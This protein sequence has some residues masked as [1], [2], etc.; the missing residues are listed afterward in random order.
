MDGVWRPHSSLAS[1]P[2]T[3]RHGTR[4][5]DDRAARAADDRH[6]HRRHQG[7]RRRRR[8]LRHGAERPSA[9]R[10]PGRSVREVEDTIVELV[11]GLRAAVRRRGGRDRGRRLRRRR[12]AP[13]VLF[14]PHLAWRDEP[15]RAA[16]MQRIAVPVVV[17][18]DANTA[19]LAE[20]RFGAG[21]RPPLRPVH[22][23]RHRHRR[24]AGDR[25]P[26]VPRRERDGRRVRPHA[27]RPGR[28]PLRVRQP[29][30]LGA[31]RLGQRAGPRRPRAG[32]APT[33]R[34]PTTCETGSAATST[35]LTGPLVTEAA[36]R[37][38]PAGRRAA[39]RHRHLARRRAGRD[40]RRVRPGLRSSSAAGS[41]PRASCCSAPP[42][43][44]S[45][46]RWSGAA[47]APSRRSSAAALGPDAG[48]VGAADMARSAARR[49]RRRRRRRER[50]PLFSR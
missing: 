44:R 45:R 40:G 12:P 49:S 22:H 17:D 39:R 32:A 5:A 11:D 48:F 10:P 43:R 38:R 8:L 31:V 16:L 1:M 20:C 13:T 7:A 46:G 24:R 29:G 4:R 19:A 47:T 25:Q 2:E 30:L 14:S 18:N 50:R 6:R 28:P 36:R 23:P 26:G 27:G 37:R 35:R 21:R 41:R 42:G 33:R 3:D 34:W 9:G 15:L